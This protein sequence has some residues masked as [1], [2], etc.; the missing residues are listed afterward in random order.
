MENTLPLRDDSMVSSSPT[1][2]ER[3]AEKFGMHAR[4]TAIYSEPIESNGVTV[5]PVA[6]VRW[7]FG[8]AAASK[9][10]SNRVPAGGRNAGLT[11]RIH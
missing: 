1:F 7:G 6:K 5:V 3:M 10:T 11:C 9:R 2:L 4:S 8:G